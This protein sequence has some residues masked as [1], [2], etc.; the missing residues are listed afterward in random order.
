MW[1]I[2]ENEIKRQEDMDLRYKNLE[3]EQ[4]KVIDEFNE[5]PTLVDPSKDVVSLED[6]E[7]ENKEL[8]DLEDLYQLDLYKILGE[9]Q[10]DDDNGD[11]DR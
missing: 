2:L 9:I 10:Q 6:K 7:K 3:E 1:E 5:E 4:Y 11:N 8:K